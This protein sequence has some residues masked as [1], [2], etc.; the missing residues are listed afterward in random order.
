MCT[1]QDRKQR[2]D[3]RPRLP[4]HRPAR[5][6]TNQGSIYLQRS[7]SPCGAWNSYEPY[8]GPVPVR[9]S[10][11]AETGAGAAVVQLVQVL[12]QTSLSRSTNE[13]FQAQGHSSCFCRVFF[14]GDKRMPIFAHKEHVTPCE[15]CFFVVLKCLLTSSA[16]HCL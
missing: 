1:R 2:C 5:T 9:H 6:R 13:L 7:H 4:C 15:P 14:L 16:Q 10:R 3:S 8:L 11:L 12:F